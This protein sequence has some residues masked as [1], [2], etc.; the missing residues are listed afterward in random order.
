MR[1]NATFSK[2][3]TLIIAFITGISISVLGYNWYKSDTDTPVIQEDVSDNG[4]SFSNSDED[5]RYINE[6]YYTGGIGYPEVYDYPFRK[7]DWYITN[8]ELHESN[9]ELLLFWKGFFVKNLC[10]II[11]F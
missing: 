9:P 5:M 6:V 7:T 4:L 11:A 3:F 1:R 10:K 2:V 8:K